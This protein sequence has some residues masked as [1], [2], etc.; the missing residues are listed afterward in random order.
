MVLFEFYFDKRQPKSK[1]IRQLRI[2]FKIYNQQCFTCKKWGSASVLLS[3]MTILGTIYSNIIELV[4]CDRENLHLEFELTDREI[5]GF[6]PDY[7][8]RVD[9][10]VAPGHKSSLC[11]AC[12]EGVCRFNL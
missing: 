1:K 5:N 4:F 7:Q 9:G 12:M 11:E 8:E 3:D 2:N 6:C 10:S